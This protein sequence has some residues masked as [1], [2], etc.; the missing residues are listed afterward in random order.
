[1]IAV[2]ALL[3]RRDLALAD[4]SVLP[5]DPGALLLDGGTTII[6]TPSRDLISVLTWEMKENLKVA[7]C[8]LASERTTS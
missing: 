3:H 2:G 8:T 1:V 4:S 6:G 7:C 5:E